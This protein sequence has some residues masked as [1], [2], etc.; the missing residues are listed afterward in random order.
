MENQDR[1]LLL[2][3]G[4]IVK[5]FISF[6]SA[7]E[8]RKHVAAIHLEG[9][10]QRVAGGGGSGG[11]IQLSDGVFRDWS[12]SRWARRMHMTRKIKL[13]Q[14]VLTVGSPGIYFIYAQINYLDDHDVNA[15]QILVNSSPWLMCTTMTHTPRATTK[16]NTCYTGGVRSKLTR[17]LFNWSIGSLNGPTQHALCEA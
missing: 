3:Y 2:K 14:G 15:F 13:D 6:R 9:E 12:V 11:R 4:F 1:I 16:A 10:V 7:V 17:I 8:S 5:G